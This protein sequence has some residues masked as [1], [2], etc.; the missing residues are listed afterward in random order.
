MRFLMILLIGIVLISGCTGGYVEVKGNRIKVETADDPEERMRGLMFRD[1][2]GENEGMLFIFDDSQTRRFWMKNTLI[3]LDIVFISED[4]EI[5]NVVEAVPCTEEPCEIYRSA[6][7]A[8]YVL[9]VNGGFNKRNNITAGDRAE[10][11]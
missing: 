10:I 11:K 8:K 3:P 4:F 1:S 5:I 7:N 9:E 6:G 2:L